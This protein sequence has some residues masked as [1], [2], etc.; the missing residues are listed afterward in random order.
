MARGNLLRHIFRH[1]SS[2]SKSKADAL[3]KINDSE[4]PAIVANPAEVAAKT[5][6]AAVAKPLPRTPP[7]TPER[8]SHTVEILPEILEEPS[9]EASTPSP[10]ITVTSPISSRT[11]LV[12]V[13]P[14]VLNVTTFSTR[15][16]LYAAIDEATA[17]TNTHLDTIET[18]LSLLRALDGFSA[19][20]D[21]L[22]SDMLRKKRVCEEKLGELE[23]LEE[24][25]EGM[26][27]GDELHDVDEG[28]GE[29]EK[30]REEARLTL[31]GSR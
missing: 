22:R 24:A 1:G 9:S 7:R 27:F 28:M 30:R 13:T 16:L 17:A 11:L 26:Q 21:V 20:V 19:T 12:P 25:V 4:K 15:D 6:V 31:E 3:P 8:D 23:S 10:S 18:T 14:A 5:A 2:H 29:V